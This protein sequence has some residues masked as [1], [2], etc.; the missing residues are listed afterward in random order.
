MLVEAL[1]K[2]IV[3]FDTKWQH[4]QQTIPRGDRKRERKMVYYH[5]S[6]VPVH[7]KHPYLKGNDALALSGFLFSI[8]YFTLIYL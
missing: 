3:P 5:L 1:D 2:N 7:Q 6:E 8:L 4:L